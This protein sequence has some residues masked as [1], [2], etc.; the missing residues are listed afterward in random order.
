MKKR[1]KAAVLTLCLAGTMM[2]G[3]A[4]PAKAATCDELTQVYCTAT[5]A[6]CYLLYKLH[7]THSPG[8]IE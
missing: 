6:A 3:P 5:G 7:V 8:C 1:V 2:I 4:A